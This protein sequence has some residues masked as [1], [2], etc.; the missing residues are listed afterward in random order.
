LANSASRA[1][2]LPL[3][4]SGSVDSLCAQ[5]TLQTTPIMGATIDCLRNIPDSL[6][7][8]T[9]LG[10]S[11]IRFMSSGSKLTILFPDS[12]SRLD[13]QAAQIQ[14]VS[15]QLETSKPAPQVVNN[16]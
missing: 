11:S 12:T 16:P 13:E 9:Y 2:S 8:I 15:A 14:K 4:L 5:V 3:G 1:A 7:P 6:R 10:K